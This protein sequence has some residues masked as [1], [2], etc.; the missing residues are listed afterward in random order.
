[1]SEKIEVI[2]CADCKYYTPRK[3][4]SKKWSAIVKAC[5]RSAFVSTKPYDYCSF[6]VKKGV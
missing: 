6:A 2:R 5:T 4:P 3:H 1:M